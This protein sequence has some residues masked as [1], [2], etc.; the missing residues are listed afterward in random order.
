MLFVIGPRAALAG[1]L[2][3]TKIPAVGGN[4]NNVS[5][6]RHPAQRVKVAYAGFL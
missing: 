6:Y 5:G 2:D 1:T 3:L 4:G